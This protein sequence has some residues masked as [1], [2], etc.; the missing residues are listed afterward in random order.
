MKKLIIKEENLNGN[1][2]QFLKLTEK[3]ENTQRKDYPFKF[4]RLKCKPPA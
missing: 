4:L 1:Q 3:E 2:N